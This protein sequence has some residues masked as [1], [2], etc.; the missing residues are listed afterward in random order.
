MAVKA[1]T[2]AEAIREQPVNRARNS[3]ANCYLLLLLSRTRHKKVFSC[4]LLW[5][6][7][8]VLV[9]LEG[10]AVQ[11]APAGVARRRTQQNAACFEGV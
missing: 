1:W 7:S 3:S 10:R 8:K 2:G 6:R 11:L 4:G 5:A 9:R